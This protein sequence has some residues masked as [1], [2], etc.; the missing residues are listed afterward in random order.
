VPVSTATPALGSPYYSDDV[1]QGPSAVALFEV[2]RTR[3]SLAETE[4]E[5]DS[6]E[7]WQVLCQTQLAKLRSYYVLQAALRGPEIASLPMVRGQHEPVAWLAKSLDVGFHP[8]SE[9]MYVRLYGKPGQ[10]EQ[11]K[12]LVDAVSKAYEDEVVYAESQAPLMKRDLLAQQLNKLEKELTEKTH[13]YYDL[14]KEQGAADTGSGRVAQELD[15]RRLDRI[16]DELMRLENAQLELETSGQPENTKFYDVRIAE[17]RKRQREL[18][19]RIIARSQSS[20][21]LTTRLREIE[22][23]QRIYNE[24]S[25]KLEVMDVEANAPPRIRQVQPAVVTG[26]EKSEVIIRA[27]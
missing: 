25:T 23:L 15:M 2:S 3:P 6:D 22:R 24:L 1:P 21:D 5:P 26:T 9:L 20:V 10:E 4:S 18:E 11:L 19:Q 13:L 12:K 17:L 8:G 7:A 14:A 16:E 27:K